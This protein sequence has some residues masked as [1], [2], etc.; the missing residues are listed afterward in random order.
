MDTTLAM[1]IVMMLWG[2][3]KRISRILSIFLRIFLA[4]LIISSKPSVANLKPWLNLSVVV[5]WRLVSKVVITKLTDFSHSF[6]TSSINLIFFLHW[7]WI[8][9]YHLRSF[10]LGSTGVCFGSWQLC[11]LVGH[12]WRFCVPHDVRKIESHS[13]GKLLHYWI[14]ICVNYPIV[15]W[16]C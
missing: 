13:I 3:S 5:S 7:T 14:I 4:G 10:S 11:P 6:N 16:F 8:F 12:D 9:S 1:T 2:L 15:N